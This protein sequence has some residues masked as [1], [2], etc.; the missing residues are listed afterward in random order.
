MAGGLAAFLG[1]DG[2]AARTAARVLARWRRDAPLQAGNGTT[3]AWLSRDQKALKLR[4]LAPQR[5]A[6]GQLRARDTTVIFTGTIERGRVSI[7][8]SAKPESARGL[9]HSP[10]AR[11]RAPAPGARQSAVSGKGSS[12]RVV[13]GG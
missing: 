13:P 10:A 2:P 7:G 12:V 8:G 11:P 9:T 5:S 3:F 6:S 4:R 1:G